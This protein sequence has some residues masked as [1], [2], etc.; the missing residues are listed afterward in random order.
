MNATIH[1]STRSL[2]L[3]FISFT[4]LFF[5]GWSH[6]GQ[7]IAQPVLH[8]GNHWLEAWRFRDGEVLET[9]RVKIY[10]PSAMR[11]QARLIS[12]EAEQMLK[13]FEKRV[14]FQLNHPVPVFL[15][16]DR[17]SLQSHF[18]WKKKQSATGVYFS[19]AIYL[20]NPEVWHE[21][22]PSAKKAPEKWARL[23][24]EKGPLYHEIAHL[25][26]D[27]ATGG[28]YPIWYTEAYAQWVE[29]RELGYEGA[30]PANR[31]NGQ[32]PYRYED[33]VH[34]FEQLPN[35]SLA[36]RQAFLLLRTTVERKGEGRLRDLH[37]RLSRGDS[38]D[39]AWEQVFGESTEESYR[40]WKRFVR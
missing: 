32:S 17:D 26:L 39:A 5:F 4:L 2:F 19:G 12:R 24:R 38:F 23:F 1:R 18:S 21:G 35:Q 36:Y 7:V 30:T 28:N 11:T 22:F 15:F 6:Q 31:L 29:Y 27:K 34:R 37:R 16:P 14:H 20:L 10:Y 8:Q 3:F 33:L 13:T 25:Y 9:T 40:H